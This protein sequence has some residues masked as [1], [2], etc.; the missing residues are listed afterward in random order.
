MAKFTI[1]S[2]PF[3]KVELQQYM[4]VA[5]LI[6]SGICTIIN[7]MKFQIPFSKRL[8]GRTLFIGSG[9]LSVM[10]TSFTFLPIFEISIRSMKAD[11]IPGE[12]AYGKMLGTCMLCALLEVVFSLFPGKLLRKIFPPVV[13]AVTVTLIGIALTGTGMKY[14][15]G[16]VVCAEMIWKEHAQVVES[17]GPTFEGFP[18]SNVP[19]AM[20]TGSAQVVLPYGSAEYIGLG[21]AVLSFLVVIELFGKPVARSFVRMR[22]MESNSCCCA[23]YNAGSIFMKNCNVILVSLLT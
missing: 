16:G 1:D 11:G 7:V 8:F 17:V 14:W 18:V 19:S 21:F 10:G 23:R 12:E 5:A 9:L 20:C 15:G 6:T 2:F 13:T 3:T 4:I 22:A